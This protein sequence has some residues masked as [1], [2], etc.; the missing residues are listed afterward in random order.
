M[1][2]K[3]IVSTLPDVRSAPPRQV[4]SRAARGTGYPTAA[5]LVSSSA[6]WQRWLEAAVRAVI[7]PAAL[8]GVVGLAASGCTQPEPDVSDEIAPCDA[9]AEGGPVVMYPI[10][11]AGPFGDG[12]APPHPLVA[13]PPGPS[14]AGGS[15]S[16]VDGPLPDPPPATDPTSTASTKPPVIPPVR[17]PA[18]RGRIRPVNVP[19][20]VPGGIS[21]VMVDPL[22]D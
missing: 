4:E 12:S 8:A 13:H 17:P 14:P 2:K 3:P 20:A 19:V 7:R 10:P 21:P 22:K 5:E 9:P 6:E 1:K 18:I 16:V 11:S 15:G